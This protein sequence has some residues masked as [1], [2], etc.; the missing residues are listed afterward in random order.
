MLKQKIAELKKYI[1]LRQQ[2]K[3][4]KAQYNVAFKAYIANDGK[5]SVL[6]TKD[7]PNVPP[8]PEFFGTPDY[9]CIIRHQGDEVSQNLALLAGESDIIT[10]YCPHYNADAPCTNK[11]C[12]HWSENQKH[13]NAE[14]EWNEFSEKYDA[15]KKQ[16]DDARAQLFGKKKER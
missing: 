11:G 3:E 15:A 7:L 14:K 9:P 10:Y 2:F 4:L 12:M 1:G 5:I 16:Y 8:R 13:F 6:K